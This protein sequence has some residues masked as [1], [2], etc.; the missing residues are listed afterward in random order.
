MKLHGN[1][2]MKLGLYDKKTL[3]AIVAESKKQLQPLTKPEK[4]FVRLCESTVHFLDFTE[5]FLPQK[6][7]LYGDEVETLAMAGAMLY[8]GILQNET[9]LHQWNKIFV[10]SF[11][12]VLMFYL[13][14]WNRGYMPGQK[15]KDPVIV[16]DCNM[17]QFDFRCGL[18]L[19]SG[20][21][22]FTKLGVLRI[23]D[24]DPNSV[25]M[26]VL[27]I[28]KRFVQEYYIQEAEGHGFM[29]D[30]PSFNYALFDSAL[31]GLELAP[32]KSLREKMMEQLVEWD[33]FGIALAFCF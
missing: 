32:P 33:F 22:H 23:A 6:L 19:A 15:K 4:Q 8:S 13:W 7:R 9:S 25:Y 20:T 17:M 10:D 18:D 2:I 29:V 21:E 1:D 14:N 26:D 24:N 12:G 16:Q 31:G 3:C 28:A 11:G 27:D 5:G 30:I